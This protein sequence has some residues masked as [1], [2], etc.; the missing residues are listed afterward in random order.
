MKADGSSTS[1]YILL[2]TMRAKTGSINVRLGLTAAVIFISLGY[3]QSEY[4]TRER[5]SV[6]GVARQ[7]MSSPG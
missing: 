4:I 3:A 5:C 7:G 1:E 2:C 6:D